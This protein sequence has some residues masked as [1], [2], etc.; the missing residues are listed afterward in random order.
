MNYRS[1]VMFVSVSLLV[2]PLALAVAAAGQEA[3]RPRGVI[4]LVRLL[5]D[6]NIQQE[7]NLTDKQTNEVMKVAEFLAQVRDGK[8]Q[9][10]AEG[11]LSA[12]L[13]ADQIN[14]LRQI[15][16]QRLDGYA[17]LEPEVAA[18]LEI[19]A[20]QKKRLLDAQATNAAEHQKMLSFISRARFRSRQ[21]LEQ[22]KAKYR[23]A[24]NR[25]LRAVLT[26]EQA[27]AFDELL[28][29]RFESR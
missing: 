11:R 1:N 25:R 2:S 16:W 4:G 14:R 3:G 6:E 21:A 29:E 8:A 7:L 5:G 22:F 13:A 18:A 26:P 23:G 27:E 20:E 9:S 12:S 15:Q 17:L 10:Q 24:A 28:G 19:T